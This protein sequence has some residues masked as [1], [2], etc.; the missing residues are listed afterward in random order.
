MTPRCPHEVEVAAAA[1][2][3]RWPDSADTQLRAHVS[4]CASCGEMA[5]LVA[6]ASIA[7]GGADVV[8]HLP[9]AAEVW[10]RLAV[11]ARLD[12]ERAAARP[13]V[14]LQGLAGA[15]GVGLVLAVVGRGWPA[16]AQALVAARG[17]IERLAPEVPRAVQP[18]TEPLMLLVL[19]ASGALAL[20]T[21]VAAAF[22]WLA[23][24]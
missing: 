2:S 11:R 8:S 22:V 4:H 15:C 14:W 5:R 12:R 20:A 7:R 10:W 19:A 16:G 6:D 17:V 1:A 9:P 3:R 18:A 24:D 13:V 23:D 21:V